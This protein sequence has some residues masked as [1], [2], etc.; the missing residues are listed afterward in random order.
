[1]IAVSYLALFAALFL[2]TKPNARTWVNRAGGR[3]IVI[4]RIAASAVCVLVMILGAL[5]LG[6]SDQVHLMSPVAGG[7]LLIG[8]SSL[9]LGI[10]LWAGGLVLALRVVGWLTLVVT[11]SVP[12]SLT[13]FLLLVAP[14]IVLLERAQ[15]NV[16]WAH[17]SKIH[18]PGR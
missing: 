14:M 7:G 2:F 15:G 6:E 4:A 17:D 9:F 18:A 16:N 1:M 5:L 13:L 11:L 12:S 10:G 3:K 8:A